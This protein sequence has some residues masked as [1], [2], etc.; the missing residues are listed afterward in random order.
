MLEVRMR[1]T[2]LQHA[3]SDLAGQVIE[4]I[5]SISQPRG[6]YQAGHPPDYAGRFVLH[7]HVPAGIADALAAP[8]P[9]LAHA[10]EHDGERPRPVGLRHGPEEHI[11]RRP[12]GVFERPLVQA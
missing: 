1:S 12:A 6:V 9:V 11:D 3:A 10:G 5:G 2:A 8:Q 7:E 4:R